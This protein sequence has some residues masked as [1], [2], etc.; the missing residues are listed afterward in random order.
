MYIRTYLE[1]VKEIIYFIYYQ[2]ATAPHK[3]GSTGVRVLVDQ[4][5]SLQHSITFT[6]KSSKKNERRQV[7]EEF[8]K[9]ERGYI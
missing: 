7:N 5:R 4:T 1:L 6:A 9:L 3:R 8:H 2:E